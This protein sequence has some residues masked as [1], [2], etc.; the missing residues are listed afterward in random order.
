MLQETLDTLEMACEHEDDD[1]TK[2]I[3]NMRDMSREDRF[4]PEATL[5]NYCITK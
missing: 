4:D 1:R 5:T 3:K 2:K